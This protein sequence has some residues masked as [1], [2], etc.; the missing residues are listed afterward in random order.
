MKKIHE[1]K[2]VDDANLGSIVTENQIYDAILSYQ[3]YVRPRCKAKDAVWTEIRS[4]T[5]GI[6]S[7]DVREANRLWDK[8]RVNEVDPTDDSLWDGFQI[9]T[10]SKPPYIGGGFNIMS[11]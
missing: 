3:R 10:K 11:I 8:Y 7:E 1:K 6:Q 4:A 9:A 5:A 2:K